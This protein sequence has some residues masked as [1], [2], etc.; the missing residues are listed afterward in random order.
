MWRL[1]FA[2]VVVFAV[3]VPTVAWGLPGKTNSAMPPGSENSMVTVMNE[4]KQAVDFYVDGE[5]RAALEPQSL[6]IVPM[7]EGYHM[8]LVD[9]RAAGPHLMERF[10]VPMGGVTYTIR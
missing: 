1:I 7:H 5:F 9:R 2:I 8:F 10:Y 6:V 4:S 3:I